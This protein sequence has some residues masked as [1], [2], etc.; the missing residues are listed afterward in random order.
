MEALD[1]LK[2]IPGVSILVRILPVTKV[3]IMY[4]TTR[5]GL[6]TRFWGRGA[7][8][9]EIYRCMKYTGIG[10]SFLQPGDWVREKFEK[11]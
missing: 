9:Y 4:D 5:G 8:M 6:I 11:I 1:K 7:L 2:I 3:G 10:L